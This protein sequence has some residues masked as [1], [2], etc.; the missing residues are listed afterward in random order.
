MNWFRSGQISAKDMVYACG[1]TW[2]MLQAWVTG[3]KK[4]DTVT[5]KIVTPQ[6]E[7]YSTVGMSKDEWDEM[8]KAIN[9]ALS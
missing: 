8:S 7:R 1:D 4:K 6:P 9:E 2:W 3:K 5:I